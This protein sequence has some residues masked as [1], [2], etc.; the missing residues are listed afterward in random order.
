MIPGPR[1]SDSGC[2]YWRESRLL[3]LP[4]KWDPILRR[5]LLMLGLVIAFGT[6]GYTMIEGW[7]PWRS[8]FFTIVTLTTV[9]YGD[10][11]ISTRGE[12]FTALVMLGGI[13]T[14]SY[15]LAQ[16]VQ[17]ITHRALRPEKRIMNQINRLSGHHIVCGAGRIGQRII[18]RLEAEGHVVVAIDTD[19]DVVERLRDRGLPALRGDATTDGA[20]HDAG[21]ERAATLAAVTPS[22][23][24][25]AMI[26]LSAHAIAPDLRL[27]ARAEEETS[28]PKLRRAGATSVLSPTVYG[29]DGIAE[30]MA[31]PCVAEMMYGRTGACDEGEQTIRFF[32]F[33]VADDCRY[34]GQS[35]REIGSANPRI[36]IIGLRRGSGIVEMRPESGQRLDGG[37][38]LLVVGHP[39]DFVELRSATAA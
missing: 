22:D 33:P 9:G 30:F 13:A 20:L 6:S 19:A 8:F 25:N 28:T 11:G 12:H 24:G 15:C 7:D 17:F 21:I 37:D 16:I 1:M 38:T 10:G 23:A 27:I 5:S 3:L 39:G 2:V 36:A 4:W 29:G 32:E 35:I 31:R 34:A 14:A 26:C 18:Q